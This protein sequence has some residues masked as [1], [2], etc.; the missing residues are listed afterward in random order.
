MSVQTI[1]QDIRNN[2]LAQREWLSVDV[3]AA[4]SAAIT[5]RLLQLPEYRQAATVLGYMNFGAEFGSETLVQ[6]ALTDGKVLLLPKVNPST[7]E[8]ELYQVEDVDAQLAPGAYGIRE[9]VAGR[10]ARQDA[11]ERIDFILLPGVAF[12][13]DGARLGYGG[14]FYDKLLTRLDAGKSP[15]R[16]P[17]LVAGAYSMQVVEN[18]PQEPGDRKVEW[19]VTESGVMQC[20]A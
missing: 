20:M 7:R 16:P 2:I 11:L 18:I 4:H 19:L 5:G 14:G 12:G 6:Q 15:A 17:A 10:C 1:K 9:P 13:R 3:R 8:L